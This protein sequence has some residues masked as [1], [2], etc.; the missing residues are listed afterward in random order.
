MDIGSPSIRR[1]LPAR[2]RCRVAY[3]RMMRACFANSSQVLALTNC[4]PTK[5]PEPNHPVRVRCRRAQ[6]RSGLRRSGSRLRSTWMYFAASFP[7]FLTTSLR[8]Q[9]E[10]SYRES[11]GRKGEL[12]FGVDDVLYEFLHWLHGHQ[13]A[14]ASAARITQA[15][16]VA[17]VLVVVMLAGIAGSLIRLLHL[18]PWW[19]L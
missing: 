7:H 17:F 9:L 13:Y 19:H 11:A 3:R 2:C 6:R 12:G 14:D 5:V 8:L 1:S 15:D 10:P 4:H 16:A 18:A